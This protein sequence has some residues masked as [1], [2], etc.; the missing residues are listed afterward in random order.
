MKAIIQTVKSA[1]VLIENTE[2]HCIKQG[3]L[4]YLSFKNDDNKQ[5]LD[6][7]VN[8]IAGLRIFDDPDGKI[9]LSLNDI[10]GEMLIISNFTIYSSLVRGFRPS[11][12]NVMHSTESVE[13][14]NVFVDKMKALFPNRVQTG[15]FGAQMEV[16]AVNDGPKNFIFEL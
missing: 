6:K 11:F 5:M 16:T 14:Y 12:D 13:L 3:M 15:K 1:D 8:K 2:R 10:N 9:N 4:V 7:M